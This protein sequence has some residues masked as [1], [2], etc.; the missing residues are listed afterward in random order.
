MTKYQLYSV[1]EKVWKAEEGD[2]K[3]KPQSH[4]DDDQGRQLENRRKRERRH[5][6]KVEQRKKGMPRKK[7]MHQKK[8]MKWKKE[9]QRKK[10]MQRK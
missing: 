6:Y 5:I 4:K 3:P 9:M 2:T 1:G 7:G 8:G 10:G